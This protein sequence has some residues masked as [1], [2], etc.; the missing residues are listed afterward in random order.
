[1]PLFLA[2]HP[3]TIRAL[4]VVAPTLLAPASYAAIPYYGLH[5]FRWIDGLMRFN[6]A[7]SSV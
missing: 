2:Q 3:E 7:S 4:P 6:P 5:A 1:M